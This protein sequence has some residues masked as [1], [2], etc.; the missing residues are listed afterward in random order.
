MS[1]MDKLYGRKT[2]AKGVKISPMKYGKM[3]DAIKKERSE[4][5]KELKEFTTEEEYEKIIS[6]IPHSIFKGE[7]NTLEFLHKLKGFLSDEDYYMFIYGVSV[8]NE[9]ELSSLGFIPFPFS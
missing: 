8:A 3:V 5:I 6:S 1:I 7:E 9:N 4:Y 2:A